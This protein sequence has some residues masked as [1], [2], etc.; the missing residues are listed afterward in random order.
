MK[1]LLRL[2]SRECR[3]QYCVYVYGANINLRVDNGLAR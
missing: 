2:M 1:V 3:E